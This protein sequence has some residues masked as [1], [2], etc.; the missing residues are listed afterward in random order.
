MSIVGYEK[1]VLFHSTIET[2]LFLKLFETC[3]CLKSLNA[4]FKLKRRRSK[5][6]KN[7]HVYVHCLENNIENKFLP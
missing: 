3:F 6:L 1:K 5:M 2:F 7:I 4:Y